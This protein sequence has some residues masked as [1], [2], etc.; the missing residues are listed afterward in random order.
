MD[1]DVCERSPVEAVMTPSSSRRRS[2]S[3]KRLSPPLMPPLTFYDRHL[4]ERHR[5]EK[6]EPF[7]QLVTYLHQAE[8]MIRDSCGEIN[9]T[10]TRTEISSQR[11][12]KG[13]RLPAL[14]DA[15]A[16]AMTYQATEAKYAITVASSLLSHSQS[17]AWFASVGWQQLNRSQWSAIERNTAFIEDFGL[18]IKDSTELEKW[19]LNTMDEKSWAILYQMKQKLPALAFWEIFCMSPETEAVLKNLGMYLCPCEYAFSP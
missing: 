18:K 7:P 5:L 1:A 4:A 3:S 11:M 19:K 12:C 17:P 8:A 9:A 15:Y 13:D 10:L 16:A 6:V 2:H 14:H